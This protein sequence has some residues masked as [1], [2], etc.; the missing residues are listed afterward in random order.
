M[1]KTK[2]SHRIPDWLRFSAF[3][4]RKKIVVCIVI[5]LILGGG[6][7][8]G[9][10][11]YKRAHT[12]KPAP[13]VQQQTP[14]KEVAPPP[15]T[16]PK[17]PLTGVEVTEAQAKRPVTAIMI[18]NSPDSRPQSGIV[19]SGVVFEAIAEGGITRFLALFQEHNPTLVGPVRS[20]RPYYVDWLAPF[21]ASVAHVGGSAKAL[22]EIR[23]GSYRDIDQFFYPDSYW[24]ADDRYAPHNVYTNFEKLD[25][26]NAEKGYTSSNFTGFPRKADK[27][28]KKPDAT[29]I[30][31]EVSGFLYNPHYDYDKATNT[32]A[33]SQ[34]G[35]DHNDRE[36]GRV[37]PKVVIAIKVPETTV[38]EDGWR[39][40]LEAIGSG[41]AYIFQ[42]GVIDIGRWHKDSR[43]GQITFTTPAGDTI[44]LNAGQTWITAIPT[45]N[46]V[47][48]Q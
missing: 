24:R 28:A 1:L 20:L 18:E 14:K 2:N 45:E 29:S 44:K 31:I 5:T 48:W 39:Q 34:A 38:M 32:Y 42:D 10:W 21:D 23:N 3:S 13:V 25:A 27:P 11:A 19:E 8:A 33:R 36:G 26:L 43:K 16:K 41:E 15:A 37:R 4:K 40:S 17:S 12:Q 46:S 30:D 22:E 6:F 35:E 7:A 9:V 47:T